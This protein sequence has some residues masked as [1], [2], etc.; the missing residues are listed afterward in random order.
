MRPEVDPRRR[1]LQISVLQKFVRIE[2]PDGRLGEPG[3]DHTNRCSAEQRRLQE[4]KH[5]L[6]RPCLVG[7]GTE[8]EALAGQVQLPREGPELVGGR[9]SDVSGGKHTVQSC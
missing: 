3:A 7:E 5:D 1:L 2:W 4:L 8:L 9:N 6:V